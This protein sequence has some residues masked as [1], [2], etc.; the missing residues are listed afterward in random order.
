MRALDLWRARQT[1]SDDG[2]QALVQS[3]CAAQLEE[4]DLGWCQCIG[5]QSHTSKRERALVQ[6]ATRYTRLRKLFLTAN[7]YFLLPALLELDAEY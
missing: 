3:A 4:L 6:L 7:R 5:L 1:L 2:L